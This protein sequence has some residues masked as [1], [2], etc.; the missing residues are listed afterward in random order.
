[1]HCIESVDVFHSRQRFQTQTGDLAC[2]VFFKVAYAICHDRPLSHTLGS[3]NCC[4]STALCFI[5]LRK[6][7]VLSN[8]KMVLFMNSKLFTVFVWFRIEILELLYLSLIFC[9]SRP[10]PKASTAWAAPILQNV[11]NLDKELYRDCLLFAIIW[12]L[13]DVTK[14]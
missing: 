8:V 6:L 7:N 11:I 12:Q 3:C 1:M 10:L 4:N 9:H 13:K 5:N 2:S 14:C